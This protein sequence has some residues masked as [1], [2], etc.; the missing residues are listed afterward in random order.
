MTLPVR[1]GRIEPP[2][3][4]NMHTKYKPASEMEPTLDSHDIV[5][6]GHSIKTLLFGLYIFLFRFPYK[7]HVYFPN[8]QG[9]LSLAIV[10]F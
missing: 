4:A 9:S 10:V 1:L 2:N 7:H 8:S 6:S 5:S 3:E